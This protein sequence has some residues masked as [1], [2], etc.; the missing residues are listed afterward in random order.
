MCSYSS[1]S[2]AFRCLQIDSSA[3]HGLEEIAA[4]SQAKHHIGAVRTNFPPFLGNS[5]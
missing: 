1:L 2:L 3:W 5:L 4:S